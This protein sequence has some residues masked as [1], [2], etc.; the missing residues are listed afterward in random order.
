MGMIQLTRFC[1]RLC[2]LLQ[3]ALSFMS[4]NVF[5][6]V[7]RSNGD[8]APN[9]I[10]YFYPSAISHTLEPA[11]P[12][13]SSTYTSVQHVHSNYPTGVSQFFALFSAATPLTSPQKARTVLPL[14]FTPTHF[15]SSQK[16]YENGS[17]NS[18]TGPVQFPPLEDSR[19]VNHN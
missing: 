19:L 3:V 1:L 4:V 16:V 11:T 15:V 7:L 5:A 17:V 9:T 14:L 18:R 6:Q 13:I 10:V 8:Y 12:V 2:L